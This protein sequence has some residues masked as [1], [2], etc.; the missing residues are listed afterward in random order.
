MVR[1]VEQRLVIAH[2]AHRQPKN[3][4]Y[5]VGILLANIS[6]GEELSRV[7]YYEVECLYE[8]V[9]VLG[10]VTK[11]YKA[12]LKCVDKCT[13]MILLVTLHGFPQEWMQKWQE[14]V[15]ERTLRMFDQAT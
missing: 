2:I 6:A 14:L 13:Q 15:S 5:Q 9:R 11:L 10:L 12:K 1:S 3:V 4:V 8:H 7:L